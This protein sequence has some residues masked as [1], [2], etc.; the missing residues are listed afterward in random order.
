ME[1]KYAWTFSVFLVRLDVY[2]VSN[3]TRVHLEA[4]QS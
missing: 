2:I 3:H 1:V 4:D